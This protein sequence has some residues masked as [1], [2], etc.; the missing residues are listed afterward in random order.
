MCLTVNK[1]REVLAQTSHVES[2]K[3]CFQLVKVERMNVGQF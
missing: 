1:S 3:M 2:E